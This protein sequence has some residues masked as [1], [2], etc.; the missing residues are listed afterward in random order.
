M[1]DAIQSNT[2]AQVPT[3]IN[4]LERLVARLGEPSRQEAEEYLRGVLGGTFSL[5]CTEA[6]TSLIAAEQ[7]SLA[8]EN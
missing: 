3:I 7:D 1:K 6:Q 8:I 2:A 5:L 4:I